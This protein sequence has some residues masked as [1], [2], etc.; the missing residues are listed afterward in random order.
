MV[1]RV[2]CHIDCSP[3]LMANFL[4][5]HVLANFNFAA[6]TLYFCSYNNY[7][8]GF[9]FFFLHCMYPVILHDVLQLYVIFFYL[10]S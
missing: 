8:P 9:G 7:I 4:N 2:Q 10:D 5:I 6:T 1:E 3:W